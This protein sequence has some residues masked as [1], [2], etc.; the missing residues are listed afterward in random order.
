[1][2]KRMS[3]NKIYVYAA[4][5]AKLY[6]EAAFTAAYGSVS[7]YRREKTDRFLFRKDKVLSLA[8]ELLL[9]YAL[10]EHGILSYRIG[11][12]KSGKPYL[13]ECVWEEGR[14][15]TQRVPQFNLSHSRERVMCVIAGQD[16]G[17]DVEKITAMEPEVAR[18]IFTSQEYE[19]LAACKTGKQRDEMFFRYWTLK[20]SFMKA[21]G[22]GSALSPDSFSPDH[23]YREQGYYF[24]EYDPVDGYCYAVCGRTDQFDENIRFVDLLFGKKY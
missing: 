6:D 17:C 3:E 13:Q 12:K 22:L 4:D 15:H 23:S 7:S 9:Q 11:V 21:T 24:K 14:M 8:A 20:E 10:K 18:Q 5:A 1:M 19:K 2:V 16:V